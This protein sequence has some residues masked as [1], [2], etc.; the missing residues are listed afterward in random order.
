MVIICLVIAIC[1]VAALISRWLLI[2]FPI[3]ELNLHPHIRLAPMPSPKK[4]ETIVIFAPH[5]DDET[6]GCGGYIQQAVKAGADLHV[7]LMTNGEYPEID[8]IL[9]EE[10]LRTSPE[11]FIKLGY[12][13]QKETLAA[14]R[15]FGLPADHVIFLGYP[16]QYLNLMWQP[17]HWLPSNPVESGRTKSTQSPYNNSFTPGAIYCGQSILSDVE[18]ILSKY[19][20]D[21]VITIHP[22][23]IHVDHWPTGAAVT[24][25]LNELMAQGKDFAGKCRLYTY[26]IH[27]DFWPEP[28]AYRPRLPLLPPQP[29]VEVHQ[30]DWMG[31]PLAMKETIDKYDAI[32]LYKTQGGAYD[33]LLLSF[34][35][36]NDLFGVY[37]TGSWPDD[38]N[39]SSRQVIIDPTGDRILAIENPSADIRMVTM[40]KSN[41]LGTV[42]ITTKQPVNFRDAFHFSI[43]AGGKALSDRTIIQYNWQGSNATGTLLQNSNLIGLNPNQLKLIKGY[44]TTTIQFP[45]PFDSTKPTFLM[46]RAWTSRGQT[47]IDETAA[48]VLRM[49]PSGE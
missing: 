32:R 45:W 38:E 34:A 36:K 2:S 33:R 16:N 5:E 18:S 19:K 26:L 42:T 40:E 22:N 20:P 23:D 15:L 17:I 8:V 12:M 29:L 7:V 10:T 1:V 46:V 9:F 49:R 28:R 11:D 24:F 41:G 47:I 6:L 37:H 35:R 13:R 43:H 48:T 30:T 3:I 25:A 27:R 21:V 4:G 31:L 44:N 39:V 14:M